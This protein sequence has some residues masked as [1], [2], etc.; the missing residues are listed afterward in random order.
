MEVMRLIERDRARYLRFVR[1]RVASQA[2]AEDVLQRALLRAVAH[3]ATLDDEERAE[4]WLFQ[5]LRNGI[6]DYHRGRVRDAARAGG[7]EIDRAV[8]PEAPEPGCPCGQHLLASL[9]PAHAEILRR[10]DAEGESVETVARSLAITVGNAYV[11]LH[12]ARRALRSRVERHCGVHSAREA[13]SCSC[14]C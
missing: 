3:T 11:R 4:A 8:A 1:S 7:E 12:R 6:A 14:D 13:M 5:I 9:T 2:D 10:V